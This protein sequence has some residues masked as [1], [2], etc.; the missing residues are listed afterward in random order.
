MPS[1]RT[2]KGDLGLRPIFHQVNQRIEAHVL[3]SF[4]AYCLYVTLEQ[5]IGYIDFGEDFDSW[6][7]KEVM[8]GYQPHRS[9]VPLEYDISYY[10]SET[11]EMGGMINESPNFGLFCLNG[12]ELIDPKMGAQW[13]ITWE[14]EVPLPA[15]Y[16]LIEAN[17]PID[18]RF[19][20]QA[21]VVFL[22]V[23]K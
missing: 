22:G 23:K 17:E 13:I 14:G 9:E 1:F 3:I 15:R 8:V 2:F 5:Y 11:T 7:L 19:A 20:G 16:L 10:W 12:R 18:E 4:L 21:E 6:V